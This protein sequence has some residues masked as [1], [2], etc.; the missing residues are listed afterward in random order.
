[1]IDP[2][3]EENG[4]ARLGSRHWLEPVDVPWQAASGGACASLE[5]IG[6]TSPV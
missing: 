2:S 4:R 6:L 1:M 5:L 3:R